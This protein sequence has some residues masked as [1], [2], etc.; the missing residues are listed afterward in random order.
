M[1]FVLSFLGC[2]TIEQDKH[3]NQ[4]ES[5]GL[6]VDSSSLTEQNHES[7]ISDIP[8]FH[9]NYIGQIDEWLILSGK[10]CDSCDEQISIYLYPISGES[11]EDS[12][13]LRKFSYPGKL[14]NYENDSLIFQSQ[15]FWGK[16]AE[17]DESMMIWIQKEL[18][19]EGWQTSHF[20]LTFSDNRIIVSKKR[21]GFGTFSELDINSHLGECFEVAPLDQTSSP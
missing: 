14:F 15:V 2:R 12:N 17:N 18:T 6:L 21:E 20:I 4:A 5:Q 19:K 11:N 8:L 10:S 9:K 7:L 16:C 3:A 1:L 13:S